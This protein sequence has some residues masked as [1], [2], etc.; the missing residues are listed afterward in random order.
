MEDPAKS[1]GAADALALDAWYRDF[2]RNAGRADPPMVT[3]G[4]L[5]QRIARIVDKYVNPGKA[6]AEGKAARVEEA[7]RQFDE[8]RATAERH[9]R[10][11]ATS[12]QLSGPW[13]ARRGPSG[14]D[15]LASIFLEC[16]A[17]PGV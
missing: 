5:E 8:W 11:D 12:A 16:P 7:D 15:A 17:P 4:S 9:S 2:V 13:T 10:G 6:K 1:P 3:D 14:E